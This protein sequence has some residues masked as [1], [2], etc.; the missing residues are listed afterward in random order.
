M[1]QTEKKKEKQKAEYNNEDVPESFGFQSAQLWKQ[2]F[3]TR[4]WELGTKP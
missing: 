1:T 4:R 2:S 3:Q